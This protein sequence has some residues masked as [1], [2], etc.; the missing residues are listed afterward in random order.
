MA[1]NYVLLERIELNASA[2][3]VTFSNIP[4]SGYTD[5]KVVVS[6]RTSASVT[7]VYFNMNFNNDTG[8][9]Y[10]MRSLSGSGATASSDTWTSQNN[11]YVY[12]AVGNTATASTFS[13]IEIYIPNYT[14]SAQKSF[15]TDG[16]AEN[17]TATANNRWNALQA[18]IWTGTAAIN[19]VSFTPASGSFVQYSTFSL[20][21]LA[22]V[23]TTPA[24][25]PKASGG[26]IDYDGTYFIH[27]FLSTGTFTPFTGLTCDYLVVAG[28]GGGGF[29][30]GGG[31]GA[32]GVKCTVGATGGSGSLP[33]ALSVTSGTP[34]TI[35]V[36]GGGAGSTSSSVAGSSG[37]N[38]IFST[39]TS[40]G[41]G[42]GG[43]NAGG[44]APNGQTGG[45]G[46]GGGGSAS[47]SSTKGT[48]SSDQ[49]FDGAN[50]NTSEAA[51][52][53]GGAAEAGNTDATSFGGDGRSISITGSAVFYGGGGGGGKLSTGSTGGDG[54]GGNGAASG[55][56]TSGTTNTGGGG[57]G[58]GTAGTPRNGG[59][60]GSG[61]V[62][63]RYLAV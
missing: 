55:T 14:S 25:A 48:G 16:V 5:L 31:G 28:G 43:S 45:S 18:S 46:G 15:S 34:Y 61:I 29:D 30:T 52:G 6:A 24:I 35:T 26:N 4:Q 54:G 62:I 50:G 57:G 36:G 1:Q 47:A 7:D 63:I 9:N 12:Q 41:G 11:A 20:Y 60:G 10:T 53:G 32:G 59:A 58:G 38:S 33:S 42:G 44:A 22:A 19:T 40:T 51:G 27:T 2:A 23:G 56:G 13:N 37:T 8:A 17:N 21:G 49:G 39:V 3:S